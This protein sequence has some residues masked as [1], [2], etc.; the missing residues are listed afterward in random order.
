MG[1]RTQHSG[2]FGQH[3]GR[4][5]PLRANVGPLAVHDG[6]L[7]HVPLRGCCRQDRFHDTTCRCETA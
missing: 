5:H 3:R 1:M 4:H 7:F 2:W 6:L